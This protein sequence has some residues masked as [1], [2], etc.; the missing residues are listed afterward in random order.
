MNIPVFDETVDAVLN[1]F[2]PRATQEYLRVLKNISE[3]GPVEMS[4]IEEIIDEANKINKELSLLKKEI[5]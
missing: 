2:V 1:C 5:F 4:I 3:S